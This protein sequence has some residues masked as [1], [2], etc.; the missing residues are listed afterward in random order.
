MNF[1]KQSSSVLLPLISKDKYIIDSFLSEIFLQ[2]VLV[3]IICWIVVP[4]NILWHKNLPDVV[5][6]LSSTFSINLVKNSWASH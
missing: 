5:F 3:Q 4:P 2:S 6:I 1:S